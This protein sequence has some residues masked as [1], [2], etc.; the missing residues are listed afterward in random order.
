[1]QCDHASNSYLLNNTAS[2]KMGG[3]DAPLL[4]PASPVVSCC[5][6]VAWRCRWLRLRLA[7]RLVPLLWLVV[8]LGCLCCAFAFARSL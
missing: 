6:R 5:L 3:V 4:A 2:R 1:M 8:V 7:L